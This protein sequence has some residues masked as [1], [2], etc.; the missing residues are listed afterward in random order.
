MVARASSVDFADVGR[1]YLAGVAC[2]LEGERFFTDKLPSNFLSIGFIFRA[3]PHARI[4]HMVRDP[5]ET[6]FSNLRELFTEVNAHS[7]DQDDLADYYLQYR[8]LMA[9]WHAVFP[10]R[11]LDVE[12]ARL[13]ASPETAMREVA[14]FCC[15]DFVSGM[16]STGPAIEQLPPPARSRSVKGLCVVN[17]RNGCRTNASCSR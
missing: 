7:Y 15:I 4:V 5:V 13:T 10:G 8:R 11:I 14:A 3:L 16:S 12:Y 6:C 1:R 17:P 9:H 2:R